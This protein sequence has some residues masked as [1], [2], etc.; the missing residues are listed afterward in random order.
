NDYQKG[1]IP[2]PS[3][4]MPPGYADVDA[5]EVRMGNHLIDLSSPEFQPQG[6]FTHTFIFGAYE[7][8]I[9]F[10]EPMITK[11]FLDQKTSSCADIRLPD[12]YAVDGYYPTKYCIRYTGE[13]TYTVSLEGM[14]PRK[15][16]Q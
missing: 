11:S 12:G 5:V 3:R 2:V 9:T 4:W 13:Q 14:Q 15:S 8:R 6:N 1:K 16:E 10:W 7:G